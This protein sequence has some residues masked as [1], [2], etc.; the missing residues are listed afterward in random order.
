MTNLTKKDVFSS[1]GNT[2]RV[3]AVLINKD[4]DKEQIDEFKAFIRMRAEENT[5]KDV[6][7]SQ[8]EGSDLFSYKMSKFYDDIEVGVRI[9]AKMLSGYKYGHSLDFE[10]TVEGM[11]DNRN[12]NRWVGRAKKKLIVLTERMF[13]KVSSR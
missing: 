6:Q 10:F 2:S 4:V 11:K 8:E 3:F 1:R 5:P 9:V 7:Y 13:D 12:A